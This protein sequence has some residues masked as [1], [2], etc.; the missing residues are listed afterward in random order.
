MD[1]E[2]RIT[3]LLER[4]RKLTD[5]A[6]RYRANNNVSRKGK[7]CERCGSTRNVELD[8]RDGKEENSGRS[9]LRWLCHSCNI[10][11]G[12][13]RYKRTGSGTVDKPN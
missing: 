1:L 5:R 9:N 6:Y 4:V 7:R 11:A 8:H 3:G 12:M 2:Q 13:A 10:K